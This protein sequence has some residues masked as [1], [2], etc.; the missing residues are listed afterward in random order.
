MDKEWLW[1]D[2]VWDKRGDDHAQVSSRVGLW[3]A[4]TTT[5]RGTWEEGCDDII[6]GTG[7]HL[8][9]S[10]LRLNLLPSPPGAALCL[11]LSGR[12]SSCG[13]LVDRR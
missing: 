12:S 4:V 10:F 5:W 9:V 8:R 6:Q 3:A 13:R 11:F 1:F 7:G 2:Q